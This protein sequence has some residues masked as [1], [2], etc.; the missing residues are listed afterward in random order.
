[1]NTWD[2]VEEIE[3]VS[4]LFE[5]NIPSDELLRKPTEVL[6]TN[7]GSQTK[8]RTVYV[9]NTSNACSK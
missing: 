8:I 5:G 1:M 9:S 3:K 4:N 6:I 7:T 2:N